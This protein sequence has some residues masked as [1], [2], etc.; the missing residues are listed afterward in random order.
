MG[1]FSEP[2]TQADGS[3]GNGWVN[4]SLIG[5]TE[6]IV[7]VVS[8]KGS[9][10][11]STATFVAL[12]AHGLSIG[13][14]SSVWQIDVDC[15]A[16]LIVGDGGVTIGLIKVD[17]VTP[18][19]SGLGFFVGNAVHI[20]EFAANGTFTNVTNSGRP[21]EASPGVQLNHITLTHAS[22]GDVV[23]YLD[24]S[25]WGNINEPTLVAGTHAMIIVSNAT[26][27]TNETTVDNLVVQ[28]FIG[29]PVVRPSG[30]VVPAAGVLRA[31]RW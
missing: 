31:S 22:N 25:A 24:G 21:N 27:P 9:T 14:T 16:P 11:N 12:K 29:T 6:P 30:L 13:S 20:T 23:A 19:L 2:F 1:T 26:S 15:T 5:S 28:D 3:L 18:D 8:N 4:D 7:Q 10:L 17:T